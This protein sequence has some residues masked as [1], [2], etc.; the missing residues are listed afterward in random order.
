MVEGD[1]HSVD[2]VRAGLTET[3]VFDPRVAADGAALLIT[4]RTSMV[5]LLVTD[6]SCPQRHARPEQRRYRDSRDT[7]RKRLGPFHPDSGACHRGE[8]HAAQARGYGEAHDER[9]H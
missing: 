3:S 5:T 9:A 7:G 8:S 1:V 2:D 6:T 4:L